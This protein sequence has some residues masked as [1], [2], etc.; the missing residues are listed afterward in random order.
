MKRLSKV[1]PRKLFFNCYPL[2]ISRIDVFLILELFISE[3]AQQLPSFWRHFPADQPSPHF[4][5]PLDDYR[6]D[7][8]VH[9]KQA[10]VRFYVFERTSLNQS[11]S[12]FWNPNCCRLCL[13]WWKDGTKKKN[14]K[15]YGFI[16]KFRTKRIRKMMTLDL[17][18]R[19]IHF[20]CDVNSTPVTSVWPEARS[21]L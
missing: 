21:V 20:M 2:I 13:K 17:W 5:T 7:H 1:R 3:N 18:P 8:S 12:Q 15:C 6:D 10:R 14:W 9:E 16:Y 11:F 4:L 19:V